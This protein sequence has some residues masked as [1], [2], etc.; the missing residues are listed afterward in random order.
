MHRKLQGKK[1]C[2]SWKI[3]VWVLCDWLLV[4]GFTGT[5]YYVDFFLGSLFVVVSKGLL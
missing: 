5:E 1:G 4:A 2:L 3:P